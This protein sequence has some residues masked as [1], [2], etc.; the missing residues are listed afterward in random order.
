MAANQEENNNANTPFPNPPSF[1][2]SFTEDNIAA[3]EA[4]KV[5]PGAK[6]PSDLSD[7]LK[8]LRPPTPPITGEYRIFG[9]KRSVRYRLQVN[10]DN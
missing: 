2:H 1:W 3:Y 7:E 6:F 5:N 8:N 10:L 9:E 4:L